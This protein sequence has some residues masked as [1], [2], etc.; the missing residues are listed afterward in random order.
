M[1]LWLY[2][3]HHVV[4]DLDKT[5]AYDEEDEDADTNFD[6]SNDGIEEGKVQNGAPTTDKYDEKDDNENN[7]HD[8]NYAEA[9]IYGH[10]SNGDDQIQNLPTNKASNFSQLKYHQ[11]SHYQRMFLNIICTQYY[12]KMKQ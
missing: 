1:S 12:M 11:G 7:D 8:N 10:I 9:S 6:V 3:K 5:V 4:L 2:C